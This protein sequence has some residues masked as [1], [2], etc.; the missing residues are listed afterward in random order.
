MMRKNKTA[1][2]FSGGQLELP[3]GVPRQEPGNR[4]FLKS[5]MTVKIVI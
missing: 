4:K 1:R 3:I 2:I 5:K